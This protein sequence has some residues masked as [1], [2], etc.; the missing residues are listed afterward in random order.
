MIVVVVPVLGRAGQQASTDLSGTWLIDTYLSDHAEQIARAIE[1]DTGEFRYDANT[2]RPAGRGTGTP[3]SSEPPRRSPGREGR[4]GTVARLS[5]TDRRVLAELTRP[6]RFPPLT[7]KISQ[8]HEALTIVGD[9]EPYQVRTDG[10]AEKQVLETESVNRTAQWTGPDL[11]VAYEVGHAGILTYNYSIV[12][13]TG[14]LLIR[15]NF[16]RVR[17]EPGPFDVKIVYNRRKDS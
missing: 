8:S 14:Q 11:R 13:T 3:A 4:G 2:D 15:I 17:D 5:E 7:L 9:R 16:E 6:V 1:F 10:K 12:P